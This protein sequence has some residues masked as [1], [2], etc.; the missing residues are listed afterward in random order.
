MT[1]HLKRYSKYDTSE[2]GTN[3]IPLET[4]QNFPEFIGNPLINRVL[5]VYLDIQRQV[6]FPEQFLYLCAILSPKTSAS[7]KRERTYCFFGRFMMFGLRTFFFISV[8]VLFQIFDTSKNGYL[9][10][11]EMFKM[12]KTIYPH[13]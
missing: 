8:L 1:K 13:G 5:I 11:E 2:K 9:Q 4:L 12:F 6:I 3:G 7:S 10:Y